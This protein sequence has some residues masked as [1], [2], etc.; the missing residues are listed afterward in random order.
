MKPIIYRNNVTKP[1]IYNMV[2]TKFY[3][4]YNAF[5]AAAWS[6]SDL[7]YADGSKFGA[8]RTRMLYIKFTDYFADI[9]RFG[10]KFRSRNVYTIYKHVYEHSLI[11]FECS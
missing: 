5:L 1:W 10:R 11:S 8:N 7:Q 9:V 2:C 3:A 6:E 4:M